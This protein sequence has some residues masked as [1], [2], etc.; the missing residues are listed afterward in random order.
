MEDLILKDIIEQDEKYYMNTF[1]KRT[2]VC[3]THG[4]G[5]YLYSTEGKKYMDLIGGIAVNVLGH[6]NTRLVEAISTQAA[7]LIH[8]S[9]LYYIQ[10]Q[11]ELA[12]KL[13][14][15][16][17]GLSKVFFAN[18]GAEANEGAI[19]L[20]R[21]Y[22]SKKNAPRAKIITAIHSF[23]GR[24]L[25]TVTAT[26]QAKYHDPFRPLPPGFIH[27]PYNDISAM[28]DAVDADTCAVMLELIQGESG[29]IP[30]TKE[31][32]QAVVACCKK[33][34]TLLIIDE[35]QT[36]MGRTGTFFTYEQYGILPDIVTLAKGLG[37]G[38]PIGALIASEAAAGG[39][40]P[41]DHGTTFGGNPLA[42]AAALA[43]LEE[44]KQKNLIDAAKEIGAYFKSSLENIGTSHAGNKS[45]ANNGKKIFDIESISSEDLVSKDDTIITDIFVNKDDSINKI[46]E[47]RGSG[48]MIGIELSRQV[49][50]EVKAKCLDKGYL[51]N[52]IG[53]NVIRLLPPLIL[54]KEDIDTFCIDF[55]EILAGI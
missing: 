1:G 6:N 7:K 32:I 41:G 35:V 5:V 4:Q 13:V 34:G 16:S 24:T 31:Y 53:N 20:A 39:F 43:V 11:S 14:D 25:A 40:A 9:N 28:E 17:K 37:G 23:H 44:Y 52:S 50:V 15:L 26:G 19:K 55:A 21:G 12:Y 29:I 46:K 3:F 51:V 42:C 8:C 22:F 36:G 38:V 27:V 45:T 49:A 10:G 30:A 48:L 2:P 18:S 54:Q 33:N 47:I